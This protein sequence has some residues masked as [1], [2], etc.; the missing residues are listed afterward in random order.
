MIFPNFL[1]KTDKTK[2][3]R[4]VVVERRQDW[5]PALSSTRRKWP[6]LWAESNTVMQ[7]KF[8]HLV[9]L[10]ELILRKLFPLLKKM[11]RTLAMVNVKAPL[12]T[13]DQFLWDL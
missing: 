11:L 12:P 7:K 5:P 10:N 8:S 1:Q 9:K 6:L 4:G 2:V 13:L 3:S